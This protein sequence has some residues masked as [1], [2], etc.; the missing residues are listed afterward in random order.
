MRFRI[1]NCPDKAF[2]PYI[3]GAAKFF[4][5][6]LIP[7]CSLKDKAHVSI[8]FSDKIE[9]QG[10]SSVAA[11]DRKCQ[12]IKFLIE[13]YPGL[14]A[15]KILATL[16]H[17]MVHVKQ[18]ILN[19]TDSA[20]SHWRG[21]KIHSTHDYWTAPWELDAYGREIGLLN[22]YA[23]E[24]ELWEVFEGF[25]NPELPLVIEPIKW[26]KKRKTKE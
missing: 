9:H 14:G 16:A 2:K 21:V 11:F 24:N 23:I 13:I 3:K 19:E 22:K 12:P 8:I 25:T 4:A 18:Y 6:H 10:F 17:E 15:K 20:L 7:D 5:D 26:I 1:I